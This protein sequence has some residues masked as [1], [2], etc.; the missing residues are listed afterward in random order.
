MNNELKRIQTYVGTVYTV[1]LFKCTVQYCIMTI[2]LTF[3]VA[4]FNELE[5]LVGCFMMQTRLN[6]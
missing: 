6:Y 1:S 2:H 3:Y 5:L 4:V